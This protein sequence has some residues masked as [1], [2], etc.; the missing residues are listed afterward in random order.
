MQ[1][2]P[3]TRPP[4]MRT[5]SCHGLSWRLGFG[6]G[7]VSRSSAGEGGHEDLFGDLKNHPIAAAWLRAESAGLKFTSNR[8][9]PH[10]IPSGSV[11]VLVERVS[12]S[13]QLILA[14]LVVSGVER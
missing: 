11:S 10:I 14:L 9:Q 2:G 7:A 13:Q 12:Q 6:V 1:L 5:G 3:P 4:K 8:F